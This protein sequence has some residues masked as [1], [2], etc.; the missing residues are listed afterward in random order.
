MLGERRRRGTYDLVHEWQSDDP[1]DGNLFV[2]DTDRAT[3]LG[4][5]RVSAYL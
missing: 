3:D 5:Y 1:D 2:C 4:A